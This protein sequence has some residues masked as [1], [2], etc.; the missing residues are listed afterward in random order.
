MQLGTTLL[1]LHV[2]NI[3]HIA[4][5][6]CTC[7]AGRH[8]AHIAGRYITLIA[9]IACT[10]AAGRHAAHIAGRYITLIAH[11]TCT[12]AAGRHAA[13]NACAQYYSYCSY[14]ILHVRVQLGATLL[15]LLILHVRVQLGAT[16]LILLIFHIACT[17]AVGRHAAN[18]VAN[19]ETVPS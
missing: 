5:I 10:C 11:I 9:H 1:I 19:S 12:C 14:F 3:T 4:H 6:T 8:A 15:I 7:A 18:I 13:H 16:L 2:R 17:C